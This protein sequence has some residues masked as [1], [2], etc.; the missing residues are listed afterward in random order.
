MNNRM[1]ISI[2]VPVYNVEKYLDRCLKSLINQTYKNYEIILVDDGSTDNSGKMCDKYA[3]NYK[4]IKAIHKKNGGLSDARNTG[5]KQAEGDYLMFVD[6]DDYIAI[7]AIANLIDSAKNNNPDII[8]GDYYKIENGHKYLN[9]HSNFRE[10]KTYTSKEYLVSSIAAGE[11]HA[12]QWTNLY[13]TDFWKENRF[14]YKKGILHEDMEIVLKEFLAANKILYVHYPFYYYIIRENSIMTGEKRSRRLYDL[15]YIYN[16][17]KKIAYEQKDKELKNAI[18]SLLSKCII[19][20]CAELEV[21]KPKYK[22]LTKKELIQYSGNYSNKFK[23]LLYI[24]N[25]RMYIRAYQ[26]K[27]H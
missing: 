1:K 3:N 19:H 20:T 12:E 7:D 17:W 18:L 13:R 16:D 14:K 25:P 8:I 9:S 5:I 15:T 6:S 24:L 11:F 22:I 26:N 23:A 2:V 10:N 21:T 27:E 4:N